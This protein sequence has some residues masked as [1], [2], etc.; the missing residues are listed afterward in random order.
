MITI[1]L[2][3]GL[4]LAII[5]AAKSLIN[6]RNPVKSQFVWP[7]ILGICISLIPA[8]PG[9]SA[10]ETGKEIITHETGLECRIDSLEAIIKRLISDTSNTEEL[11]ELAHEQAGC[12]VATSAL[13]S[14]I[15]AIGLENYDTALQYLNSVMLWAKVDSAILAEVYFFIGTIYYFGQQYELALQNIDS[16]IAYRYDN[17]EAWNN[18]GISLYY[19]SRSEEAIASYD[20]AIAYKHNCYEAWFSRG[21]SFENIG[22]YKEAVASYDSAISYKHDFNMAWYDRGACL[23]NLGSHE[24]AIASFDSAIRIKHDDYDAWYHRGLSLYRLGNY[25]DAITSFD[26]LNC[27]RTDYH[28]AWSVRAL[29][30]VLIGKYMD[31]LASCDSAIKYGPD[32]PEYKSLRQMILDEMDK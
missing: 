1:L 23:S 12:V 14:A 10:T 25:E 30:L 13:D 3:L 20:S 19:L 16:S 22:R 6:W 5:L 2:V 26:S 17:H 9:Y 4:I 18:R 28:L 32:N 7:G 24:E 8:V 21:V 27:Y 11:W 31:A 29:C 15:I